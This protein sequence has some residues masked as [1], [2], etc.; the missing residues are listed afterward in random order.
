MRV[1]QTHPSMAQPLLLRT[2]SGKKTERTPVWLMRQAGRVL[3]EYRKLREK[4]KSFKE[5]VMNPELS[6]EATL[7]PISALGVDAAIIFSDIMVVSEEMGMSYTMIENKGPILEKVIRSKA[8]IE[9][10]KP[11]STHGITYVNDA[12][13]IVKKELNS[14]VPL[15][16]FSGAPWTLFAY[17]IEGQGSKTFSNAKKFLYTQPTLSHFLLRKITKSITHYLTAQVKNGADLVQIFDSWAGILSPEQYREFSIPYLNEISKKL[18]PLVPVIV[19]AKGA[20]FSLH[21]IAN[22]P[23]QVIGLDWTMD[24]ALARKWSKGKTLQGNMDPCLLYSDFKTIE[25]KTKEMLLRFG[26]HKHIAN[27]GHGL[28]PDTELDK[29]KCFVDTV[30][31]FRPKTPSLPAVPF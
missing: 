18:S 1:L 12:I 30:K 7:Q 13:R 28:Y 27:L 25:R 26:P 16:G 17:M 3:P 14:T 31:G 9:K 11:I 22:L 6:A 4:I 2:I 24:I 15:I 29:V 8:D 10:L 21:E 23:C 20:N 5:L 19:F